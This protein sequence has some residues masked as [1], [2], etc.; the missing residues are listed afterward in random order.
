MPPGGKTGG[1]VY[2]VDTPSGNRAVL[3]NGGCSVPVVGDHPAAFHNA[4]QTHDLGYDLM[5]CFNS[6]GQHGDIR[7]AVDNNFFN[8]L[9]A[10]VSNKPWWRQPGGAMLARLYYEACL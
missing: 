2:Y 7:K 5:R 8:D 10:V 3:S 1:F 4:C 9:K 6:S